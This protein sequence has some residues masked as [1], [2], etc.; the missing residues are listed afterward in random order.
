M[1]DFVAYF[2]NGSGTYITE[3]L[4]ENG[5]EIVVNH[6]NKKEY[7][8]KVYS[9]YTAESRIVLDFWEVFRE[10]DLT[11]RKSFL[12]FVTA[13]D[14]ISPEELCSQ[15]SAEDLIQS[16]YPPPIPVGT[17][18]SSQSIPPKLS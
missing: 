10:M 18:S 2:E 4:E 12:L 5:S 13:S 3:E 1:C 7:S 9:E 6:G 15:S 11:Q 16:F 14:W 8:Y 17:S